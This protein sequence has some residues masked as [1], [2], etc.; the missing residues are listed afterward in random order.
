MND[1]TVMQEVQSKP[2]YY[3]ILPAGVRYDKRLAP[4]ERIL[5][6]EITALAQKDG[7][8]WAKNSYFC[9]LFEASESTVRRWVSNLQ[10]C[11]YILTEP[12]TENGKII[13]RRIFLNP[14]P[15]EPAQ[16]RA[17]RLKMSGETAQNQAVYYRK[18]NTSNN[19]TPLPPEGE[20]DGASQSDR[21][22]EIFW[23]HYPRKAD[24][25]KAR[26]AWARLRH[27]DKLFPV[28]MKALMAQKRSEQWQRE[29]G[30]FVPLPSTWLN[31]ERWADDV[32]QAPSAA[33]EDA[34]GY[35]EVHRAL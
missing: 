27:V 13:G 30:R 14:Q 24:K 35:Q 11:G 10:K 1:E 33:P 17:D 4:M 2:G 31:G 22:F 9:E 19:N 25:K 8:C 6:A 28:L 34:Y 15:S 32:T 26:R 7:S 20:C 21:L 12:V 5:Y 3:A 23:K 29:G 16:N 18:N